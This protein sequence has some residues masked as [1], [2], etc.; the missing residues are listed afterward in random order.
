MPA[1]SP[2]AGS[3]FTIE[4]GGCRVEFAVA[5]ALAVAGRRAPVAMKGRGGPVSVTLKRGIVR[6][7]DALGAWLL[8]AGADAERRD[9]VITLLDE[10]RRPVAAWTARRA[11]PRRVSASRVPT[12]AGEV[13]VEALELGHEGLEPLYKR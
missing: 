3:C 9:V 2:V 8:H 10:A 11:F 7:R 1:P 6:A 13:A 5:A 4:W 12:Q